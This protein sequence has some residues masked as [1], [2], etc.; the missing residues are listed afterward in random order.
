LLVTL[1]PARGHGDE[2]VQNHGLPS[3]WTLWRSRSFQYTPNLRN[4]NRVE[5]AVYFNHTGS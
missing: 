2:Q 3:G 4:F 5:S 1:E